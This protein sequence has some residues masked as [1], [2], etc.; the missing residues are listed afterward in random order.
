M[1]YDPSLGLVVL[2]GGRNGTIFLNDTWDFD[3]S[4]GGAGWHQV[5]PT[6]APTPRAYASMAYN[7]ATGNLTLFGGQGPS[8]PSNVTGASNATWVFRGANWFVVAGPPPPGRY[9]AGLTFDERNGRLVLFGGIRG[10]TLF[11]DTWVFVSGAWSQLAT[12]GAPPPRMDAVFVFDPALGAIVLAG[13]RGAGGALSD[14]WMLRD[15]QWTLMHPPG[16]PPSIFGA[17]TTFDSGDGVLLL[18]G[19]NNSTAYSGATYQ[20]TR[21]ANWSQP[22]LTSSLPARTFASETFDPSLGAVLLFG[23]WNGT[24]L[25]DSWLFTLA[26]ATPSWRQV[27]SS[28]VPDRRTQAAFAYDA[29][30]GYVVMMGGENRLGNCV[31]DFPEG[32][33]VPASLCELNDTWIF[34]NDAWTQL[35]PSPSVPNPPPGARRGA[36]ME[37]DYRDGYLVLFGGSN[38]TAYLNDTWTFRGGIWTQLHPSASPAPRRSGGITYDPI[39]SYIMLF[40]GHNGSLTEIPP[41]YYFFREV[42]SFIAG[43]WAIVPSVSSPSNTPPALAEPFFAFDPADGYVLMFGGY[44]ANNSIAGLGEATLNYTYTYSGGRWTNISNTFSGHLPDARDG[45]ALVFDAA[46]GAMV[47]FGGDNLTPVVTDVWAFSEGKWTK[48]CNTCAPPGRAAN[49]AVFDPSL[50]AMVTF[51][52]PNSPNQSLPAET[53]INV[54]SLTPIA[55]V[56]PPSTDIGYSNTF[57]ALAS[58]G[59]QPLTPYWNLSDGTTSRSWSFVHTF[60]AVSTYTVSLSI[61]D[62]AGFVSSVSTLVHINNLPVASITGRP[63]GPDIQTS[64]FV[65]TLPIQSGTAP[66]IYQ[67]DFGDGA[68]RVIGSNFTLWNYG[69]NGTFTGSVTVTDAVG[70][71]TSA[72]A[73]PIVLPATLPSIVLNANRTVTAAP[74]IVALTTSLTDIYGAASYNFSLNKNQTTT[75]A[76]IFPFSTTLP[77]VT[78]KVRLPGVISVTVKMRDLSNFTAN[79]SISVT[80]LPSL[81]S[82]ISVDVGSSSCPIAVNSTPVTLNASAVG[83]QGPYHFR[84][85]IG[86]TVLAGPVVVTRLTPGTSSVVVLTTQDSIN[87]NGSISRQVLIPA[88][89]CGGGLPTLSASQL[90]VIGAVVLLLVVV[91]VE[92]AILANRRSSRPGSPKNLSERPATRP[93]STG[94]V[95]SSDRASSRQDD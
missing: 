20:L 5:L 38:D 35:Y 93:S 75:N 92:A 21:D 4:A 90:L 72:T 7:A 78:L 26:T 47:V 15:A 40:G 82:Q 50:G 31:G 43:K 74:A 73:N 64:K 3:R 9:G 67:Y 65:V 58:G 18:A 91:L 52:P 62:G 16:A 44:R 37:Y 83:G 77:N 6:R 81:V 54:S 24:P 84:W 55:G 69:A 11:N 76:S 10:P 85:L 39:D 66:F 41:V 86:T 80:V 56:T 30:D 27:N 19:G 89:T 32:T 34:K 68:G 88:E 79:S 59:V 42:W 29:A 33:S 51:G 95:E 25:G 2:F 1:A 70:R 94:E 48:D 46:I 36:M 61:T 28:Q 49:R 57:Q 13:G 87:D 8:G 53:W 17:A 23:G 14:T 22:H 71:S 45:G 12:T 60:P 63:W